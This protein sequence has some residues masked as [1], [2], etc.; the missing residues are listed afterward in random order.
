MPLMGVRKACQQKRLGPA[1]AFMVI[2]AV[3]QGLIR[4]NIRNVEL[5]W[6]LEDNSG[7]RNIIETIGGTVSK[8]YRVYEKPL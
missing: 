1:L 6:I 8:R 3:R 2:D 4:R 5:S 7:M